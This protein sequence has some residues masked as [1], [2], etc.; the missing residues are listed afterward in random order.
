MN[1]INSYRAFNSKDSFNKEVYSKSADSKDF[2]N[3]REMSIV[4]DGWKSIQD[5]INV[6]NY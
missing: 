5:I 4:N 2:K 6:W 1:P 3:I